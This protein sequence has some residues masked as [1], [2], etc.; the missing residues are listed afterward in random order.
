MVSSQVSLSCAPPTHATAVPKSKTLQ[1]LSFHVRETVRLGSV[2]SL[3]DFNIHQDMLEN[4]QQC[5]IRTAILV[6]SLL[7]RSFVSCVVSCPFTPPLRPQTA[8]D[9]V[10]TA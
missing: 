1:Y 10:D 2:R 6:R 4:E 7:G 9:T 5:C 8:C 3:E